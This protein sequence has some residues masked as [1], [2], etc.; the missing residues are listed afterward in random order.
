MKFSSGID[1]LSQENKFLRFLS[2]GFLGLIAV[3]IGVVVVLFDKVPLIVE[4]SSHG[5]EI[6][7]TVP[8]TQSEDDL[9]EAIKLMV[10]SRFNSEAISP[11]VFLN[12]KQLILRDTEE[13]ELK[14][15][16]MIQTVIVRTVNINK[17]EA[18][19]DLDRIISVGELRSALRA[20]IRIA[21]EPVSAN[22]LNP[23]GLLLS[24]AEP[25]E[26]KEEHK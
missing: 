23:Y 12:Q 3:L 19:V 26:P 8:A 10:H 11:E 2:M 1:A 25:I 9:K 15:R 22:E 14:A 21:F 6:I 24:V 4:R 5:L 16:N 13:K 7:K 20:R 18:L 17:D